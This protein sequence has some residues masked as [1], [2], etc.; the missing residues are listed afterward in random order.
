[1]IQFK[2]NRLNIRMIRIEFWNGQVSTKKKYEKYGGLVT[3]NHNPC[4]WT[5][6][7]EKEKPWR[8]SYNKAIEYLNQYDNG[9]I[10]DT[11]L[12]HCL[13]YVAYGYN[14][15]G[16]DKRPYDDKETIWTGNLTTKHKPKL[17]YKNNEKEYTLYFTFEGTQHDP[18]S[19]N[20][21]KIVKENGACFYWS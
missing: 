13:R 1:M 4:L 7:H 11:E 15:D 10:D 18:P 16:E 14:V 6:E 19:E 12:L 3:T 2:K 20:K 8:K 21:W 5:N 9:K 17:V